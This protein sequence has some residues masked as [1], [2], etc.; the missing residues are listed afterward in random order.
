MHTQLN[1]LYI[2]WN[3]KCVIISG[4]RMDC[5][6]GQWNLAYTHLIPLMLPKMRCILN[7]MHPW[8]DLFCL[9]IQLSIPGLHGLDRALQG[10]NQ[11]CHGMARTHG[12]QRKGKA[13]HTA[14]E[15]GITRHGT[16]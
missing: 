5:T 3:L 10:I 2:V 15:H 8:K 11:G 7:K 16:A 6:M 1:A 13:Q 14:P 4:S 12:R 9:G